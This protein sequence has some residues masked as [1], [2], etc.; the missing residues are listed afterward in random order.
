N[1]RLFLFT[2]FGLVAG[3][4]SGAAQTNSAPAEAAS[5]EGESITTNGVAQTG[6]TIPLI[7]MDEVQLTDAIRNL[8]RQ[9]GLNFML[10]PRISFGQAGP[11]CKAAPQPTVS[12]RWENVTAEQALHARLNNYNLQLSEDP[13]SKIARITVRDPAAPEPLVTKIIRLNF[14]SPTNVVASVQAIID[15]KRGKVV[16]DIRT[17][18]LVV[19]ATE[20]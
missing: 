10:D 9:A 16:A 12:V 11:G 15:T 17:S 7:V 1:I 5:T 13:K 20:K 19:L 2:V 4:F 14:A 3:V 6:A 18:Q 8:A